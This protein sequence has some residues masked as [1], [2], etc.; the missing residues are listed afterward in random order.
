MSDN[1]SQV[2]DD[3]DDLECF[4]TKT[5]DPADV[6]VDQEL[7]EYASELH[8]KRTRERRDP[9]NKITGAPKN[10]GVTETI[11]YMREAAR[12]QSHSRQGR[13]MKV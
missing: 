4:F 5:M 7:S 6:W 9:N 11:H 2:A 8:E 1:L 12:S 13:M 3:A 10:A